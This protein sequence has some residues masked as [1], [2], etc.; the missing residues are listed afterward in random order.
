[1]SSQT[2]RDDPYSVLGISRDANSEQIKS[3]Y[4]KLAL[5]FHPDK[6]SAAANEKDNSKEMFCKISNAY[7]VLSDDRR[8]AAYDRYG[9]AENIRSEQQQYEQQY[10]PFSGIFSGFRGHSFMNEDPFEVFRRV[11]AE[12]MRSSTSSRRANN[13]DD[14]FRDPFVHRSFGPGHDLFQGFFNQNDMRQGGGGGC[15]DQT[16]FYSSSSSTSYGGMRGGQSETVSTTTRVINGKR[17]TITERTITRP[18]GTIERHSD[19]W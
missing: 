19:V 18:D 5:R 3:A 2:G 8:R 11:F 6:A 1:M 10:T 13:D 15:R 14:F 4:R 12:E 16:Q 9:H 7:S 17:Q